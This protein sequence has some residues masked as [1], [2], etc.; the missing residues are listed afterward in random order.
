MKKTDVIP[1]IRNLMWL[2]VTHPLS[3]QSISRPGVA[4]RISQPL[5]N[6][7]ICALIGTPP[8][9]HTVLRWVPFESFKLSSEIWA[10]NSLVGAKTST[11]GN[12]AFPEI[13]EYVLDSKSFVIIGIRNAAV[14]PEPVCAHPIKSLSAATIGIECCWIEV[15]FAYFASWMFFNKEESFSNQF[16][17]FKLI[18]PSFM[19]DQSL[20]GLGTSLPLVSTVL[21]S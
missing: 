2:K 4:I 7:E 17:F 18:I 21:L 12:A 11:Q 16:C 14:L 5:T 19:S 10:A 8:K 20:I 1:K 9:T 15:G 3:M 6:E 13:L